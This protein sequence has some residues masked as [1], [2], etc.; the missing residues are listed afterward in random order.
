M[1]AEKEDE[2]S[3]VGVELGGDGT[4]GGINATDHDEDVD[5]DEDS[6]G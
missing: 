2:I 6:V 3:D 4:A 5:E 1:G